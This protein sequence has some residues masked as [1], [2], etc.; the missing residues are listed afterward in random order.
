[1]AEASASPVA[2]ALPVNELTGA[3]DDLLKQH[4]DNPV[5][6][7]GTPAGDWDV[8]VKAAELQEKLQAVADKIKDWVKAPAQEGKGKGNEPTTVEAALEAATQKG[9]FPTRSPA[10]Y[11]FYRELKLDKRLRAEYDVLAKNHDARRE[12][13]LKFAQTRYEQLRQKRAKKEVVFDLSAVDGEYCTFSRI[14]MRE[15]A[16]AQDAAA[17]ETAKTYVRNAVVLWQK[18]STFHGH[19]W[20]KHDKMRGGAVVL[21]VRETVS[22]GFKKEWSLETSECSGVGTPTPE[23]SLDVGTPTPKRDLQPKGDEPDPKK[24]AKEA[25]AGKKRLEDAL[26]KAGALK[27]DFQKAS[28]AAHDLLALV[29][30][31][32]DWAWCNN[33]A[34]LAPIRDT[35]A[36]TDA[37]K[38]SNEFWQAWVVEDNLAAY[39]RK[40]FEPERVVLEVAD[41][42]RDG[43]GLRPLTDKLQKECT[44][45]K[46]MQASRQEA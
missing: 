35:L 38:H 45:L 39:A 27:R 37:Y 41:S 2:P 33:D 28:Q 18:G 3:V 10:G 1:M 43:D 19:P 22:S 29:A 13:R 25:D 5:K 31:N 8:P 32:P 7:L 34:L 9:D 6:A 14:V 46:K 12:F 15:G 11:Y 16:G 17:F 44:R 40:H 30:T 4:W 42:D 20:V 21:H 24:P 36:Q 26:K 23:Q